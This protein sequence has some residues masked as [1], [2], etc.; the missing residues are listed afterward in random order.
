MPRWCIANNKKHTFVIYN[1]ITFVWLAFL[2]GSLFRKLPRSGYPREGER[3]KMKLE[4][5]SHF[6]KRDSVESTTLNDGASNLLKRKKHVKFRSWWSQR[7]VWGVWILLQEGLWIGNRRNSTTE[8]GVPS[9]PGVSKVQGS[10]RPHLVRAS[11]R[12]IS[13]LFFMISRYCNICKI[14][15]DDIYESTFWLA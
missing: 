7:E 12:R 13:L 9:R 4:W 1:L 8:F 5:K 2:I 10:F 3:R 6:K 11:R 15:N 14:K